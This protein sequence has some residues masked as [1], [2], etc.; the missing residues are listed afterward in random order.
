MANKGGGIRKSFGSDQD[1]F[2]NQ[3]QTMAPTC[4][5]AESASDSDTAVLAAVEEGCEVKARTDCEVIRPS[6][7]NIHRDAFWFRKTHSMH[8]VLSETQQVLKTPKLPR[9]Q[10]VT[11]EVVSDED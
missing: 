8:V 7:A 4:T 10:V 9:H 6:D 11:D 2:S 5:D 1:G 3:N